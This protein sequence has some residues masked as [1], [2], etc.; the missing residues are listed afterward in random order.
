MNIQIETI[1]AANGG[2]VDAIRD[3][4]KVRKLIAITEK[5]MR[6]IR[7]F[8]CGHKPN[9]AGGKRIKAL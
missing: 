1:K 4:A 9:G 6:A 8:P 2:R 3:I 7:D 5:V